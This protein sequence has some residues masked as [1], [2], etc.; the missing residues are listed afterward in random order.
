MKQKNRWAT[1]GFIVLFLAITAYILSGLMSLFTATEIQT[2]NTL[3]IPIRGMIVT[4][5]SSSPWD[6]SYTSSNDIVDLLEKTDKDPRIKAIIL[7]INSGGG[8]AV[9]SQEIMQKIKD[10]NKTTVS[11]IRDIGA[12]G[13]YWIA[14][15]TDRIIS[16]PLSY[17]GSIGVTSSYLEFAGLLDDFNITYRRLVSGEF[18]DMGTPYKEMTEEER[19]ILEEDLE[20]VE[21]FFKDSVAENR[22]ISEE[23]MKGI[24]DGRVFLGSEALEMELVDSLGTI[25]TAKEFLTKELNTSITLS[26]H[27]KSRTL[28]DVLSMTFDEK[29]YLVGKGMGD[30]LSSQ[31]KNSML[32]T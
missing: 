24:A 28:L 12:S 31:D 16:N 9:A 22:G 19:S 25:D 7:E 6:P 26:R 14:S 29:F 27:K 20:I 15:A 1:A 10:V 32:R 2:G 21:D 30:S 3:V 13:A 23:M 4:E 5:A 11:V 18:K 8:S 17:V